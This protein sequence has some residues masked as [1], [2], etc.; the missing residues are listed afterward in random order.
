[1]V[2][3]GL[4]RAILSRYLDVEPTRLHF[5]DEAYREPTLISPTPGDGL[6]LTLAHAHDLALIAIAP[7]RRIGVSLGYL[8]PMSQM[9]RI[10]QGLLSPPEQRIWQTLPQPEKLGAFFKC[11]TCK[12]AYLKARGDGRGLPPSHVAMDMIPGEAARL[13]SVDGDAGAPARWSL[14]ELAPAPGYLAA[15]AVEGKGWQLTCWHYS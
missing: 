5:A 8:H 7:R 11:W 3:R 15:L 14:R 2:A 10:A 1:M 13:L 4:L 9:E 12:E 6:S